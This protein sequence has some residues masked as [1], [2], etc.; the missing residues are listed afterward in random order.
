MLLRLPRL[1]LLRR[2]EPAGPGIEPGMSLPEL[3]I[4][5]PDARDERRNM[6]AGAFSCSLSD[7]DRQL[8]QDAEHMG[9]VETTDTITLENFGDGRFADSPGL[10]GG[11]RVLPQVEQPFRAEVAL[12]LEHGWK[13]APQQFA[14]AVGEACAPAARLR[15]TCC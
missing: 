6:R 7:L 2:S 11:R 14:D 13:V 5:E 12:E 4:H 3:L 15:I 8:A 10:V 1:G 9:G